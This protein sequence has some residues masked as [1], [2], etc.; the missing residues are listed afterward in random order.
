[1]KMI[2]LIGLAAAF[3]LTGCANME[4]MMNAKSDPVFLLRECKAA[5]ASDDQIESCFISK[6]ERRDVDRV[7]VGLAP[8]TQMFKDAIKEAQ[9]EKKRQEELRKQKEESIQLEKMKARDRCIIMSDMQIEQEARKAALNGDYDRY[10]EL[11]SAEFQTKALK[12][13]NDLAK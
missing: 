2:K 5:Y 1:M 9:E 3:M 6:M 11:N 13:C 4:A 12:Y 7:K 10:E 8:Q